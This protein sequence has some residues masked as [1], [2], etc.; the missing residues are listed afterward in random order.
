VI[1]LAIAVL[2]LVVASSARLSADSL[3]QAAAR[4]KERRAKSGA[5]P[6]TYTEEDLKAAAE[7]RAKEE[8]TSPD[9]SASPTPSPAASSPRKDAEKTDA[10]ASAEARQAR[11]ALYKTRLAEANAQLKRAEAD[12]KAAEAARD[13]V[14]GLQGV[15]TTDSQENAAAAV[16]FAKQLVAR[17]RH[18]RDDLEDAARREGILPGELR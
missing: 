10:K 13:K 9:T 8:G 7:K 18:V 5:S 16:E 15:H 6:K 12:L 14:S 3:G 4:E 17:A 2:A 11:A 1:R